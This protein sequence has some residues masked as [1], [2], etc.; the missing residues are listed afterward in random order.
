MHLRVV[1][2]R[3]GASQGKESTL[4]IRAYSCI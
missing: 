4:W 2:V 3:P 1:V